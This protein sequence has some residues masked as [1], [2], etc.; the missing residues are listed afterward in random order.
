MSLA[1]F[2]AFIGGVRILGVA[3]AQ[4]SSIVGILCSEHL[5]TWNLF[6]LHFG[7]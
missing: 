5:H 2:G 6:V 4:P 1:R 3:T 7:G